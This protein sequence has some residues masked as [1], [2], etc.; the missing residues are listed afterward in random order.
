MNV[1]V[2]QL[3]AFLAV[4]EHRSFTR[5][6]E[7]LHVAQSAVSVLV[8]ELEHELGIRLFDRTTRRVEL[9]EPGREF[10]SHAE[11]LLADLDHAVRNAHDLAARRRGRITV[12][13]PPL[14]AATLLPQVIATFVQRFPGVRVGLIDAGTD[15]IVAR[16][17]SGEADLGVG[18]FAPE[19]DGIARRLLDRDTLMLFCSRKHA[20]AAR[21]QATW[22]DLKGQPL[23]ALTRDS[24]IRAL[25]DGI[26]EPA[27]LGAQP[28]YEVSHIATALAL[29]EAGLGVSVLPSYALAIIRSRSIVARRLINPMVT[30]EIV[31]ISGQGRSPAPAVPDL[32]ELLESHAR[33]INHPDRVSQVGG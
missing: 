32:I 16:V 17:R 25:V 19:E 7:R 24:G 11:K 27:G 2:R 13:A 1:T 4:A 23:I 14:L 12:A 3:Q 9:T 26:L 30:R 6:A 18:T 33:T 8:R 29:V 10:R 22:H 21:R 5:A 20:L 31:V 28:A 15:Q